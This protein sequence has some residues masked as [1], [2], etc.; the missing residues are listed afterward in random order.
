MIEE[1]NSRTSFPWN[2]VVYVSVTYI[3]RLTGK[4]AS[5]FDPDLGR[6]VSGTHASGVVVGRI[7][8]ITAVHVVMAPAWLDQSRYS[9]KVEVSPG[10]DSSPFSA[11]LGS[12][13]A[14]SWNSQ[15]V[16]VNGGF[17][18]SEQNQRDFALLNFT[19]PLGDKLGWMRLDSA[20]RFSGTA[21][22]TGYPGSGTGMMNAT[23]AYTND[24]R[25]YLYHTTE[26]L[27]SGASGGP[28][29]TPPTRAHLCSACSLRKGRASAT[30]RR[31]PSRG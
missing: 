25:Y 4:P 8:V 6:T 7:D 31:S 21:N 12:Y 30:T 13:A 16:V 10:A 2:A 23:V 11:P 18:T 29:G 17:I 24:W 27:G 1:I 22:E 14:A 9:I 15:D 26:P 3:D 5:M 28:L 19:E 20:S